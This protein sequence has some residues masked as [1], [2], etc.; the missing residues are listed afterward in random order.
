VHVFGAKLQRLR[1]E[2]MNLFSANYRGLGG[3]CESI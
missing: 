3:K 1:K 2:N